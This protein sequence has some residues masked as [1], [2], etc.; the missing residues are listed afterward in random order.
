MAPPA[1]QRFVARR[2]LPARLLSLL[3]GH[4]CLDPWGRGLGVLRIRRCD[5][6]QRGSCLP[7]LHHPFPLRPL[8]TAARF[9]PRCPLL[10]ALRTSVP[11]LPL[12]FLRT[13]GRTDFMAAAGT[14]AALGCSY[15]PAT[16]LPPTASSA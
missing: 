12:F 6:P 16:V 1:G 15:L 10:P 5:S 4:N 9:Y 7:F 14:A 2:L 13:S 11:P 8:P 3:L